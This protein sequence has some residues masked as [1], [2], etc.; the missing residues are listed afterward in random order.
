MN[1]FFLITA[2]LCLSVSLHTLEIGRSDMGRYDTGDYCYR[3]AGSQSCQIP[4]EG[5]VKS[6]TGAS[7]DIPQ[8]FEYTD[9][10]Y[11]T[12]DFAQ[13][14]D[15]FP[16]LKSQGHG[17]QFVFF[18]SAAT[19]QMPQSVLDAILD[20]YR[21]YKSNVGR[22][23]YEFAERATYEFEVARAKV[24]QFIG[25]QSKEIVLTSGA[26][27][28]INL[29]VDIWA[30]SAI[31]AG[32][33]II[34][35]HAEHNA[36]FIPWQQLAARKGAKL[37]VIPL[38]DRAVMDL[39]ALQSA[40]S[41]KTKLVALTHQSNVLGT[42]NDIASVAKIAH[43]VG[44]KVLVDGAQSV[45]H[46]K[47]DVQTMDCDFLVFSAHKLYGPTGAGILYIKQDLH[48]Q[49][50]MHN[51]GGGIVLHVDQDH[52]VFKDMP[53]RL[54]PGT[55]AI[56]SV[57]GLGA[58][59]DFVQNHINFEQAYE[60]ETMLVQRLIVGLQEISGITILSPIPQH[61]E[62]NNMV[63][64]SS[65]K[66]HGY[67]IAEYLDQCGIAI[68]A[69]Y[70]CAQLFYGNDHPHAAV[71]VSFGV[72]NTLQEVDYFIECMKRLL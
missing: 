57:I 70:H 27:A 8:H 53:Y 36:N 3:T 42:V 71:R 30:E 72:Y 1:K 15:Q 61:N 68:R 50:S 4:H 23:M 26:T 39:D 48:D 62:H 31:E 16:I 18:D 2:L 58:A 60:H 11:K 43:A 29:V 55:P 21:N 49:C 64:F 22:G 59:I 46:Q 66:L 13:V 67:D 6:G 35:S 20:Y 41:E 47:I 7:D 52:A 28:S 10:T 69:G 45:A 19:A 56:A 5:L 24:A 54:E 17:K 25:A 9:W 51:F 65:D 38:T 34:I 63:T 44:A 37:T 40:V 32:D 14:R 12:M 33:E